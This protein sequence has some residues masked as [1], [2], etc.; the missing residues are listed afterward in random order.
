GRVRLGA[1]VTPLARRRPHKVAR[2]AVSLDHL[3]GG[4]AVVGVGLGI[5]DWGEYS[6]FDEPASDD[7]NRARLLDDGIDKILGYWSGE[8]LP[9]PL[10]TPRIPI[11]CAARYPPR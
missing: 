6:A 4:R 1:V 3:S 8:L 5:D 9:A 7:K 11:W 10:Q 2:E